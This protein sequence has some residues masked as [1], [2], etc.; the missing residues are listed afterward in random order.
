MWVIGLTGG[1]GS[2]K[3]TVARWLVERGIPVLDADRTVHD[4]LAGDEETIYEIEKEF[5]KEVLVSN[6]GI[7]RKRLGNL[8]FADPLARKRLEGILHPRVAKRM[9]EQQALLA[10]EGQRIC[11]WD[12][13]LLFE[14]GFH[15]WVD[16]IWVVAV[17]KEVQIERI[18]KRDALSKEEVEWRLMAQ[19]PL[20]DKVRQAHVVIDNSG[21]WEATEVQLKRELARIKEEHCL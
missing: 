1:M 13:P 21:S 9:K 5:G 17:P 19:L 4:L 15:Y 10:A 20:E 14:A 12:V 2:G 8:V 6:G 18:M 16:E 11:V 7:H 3:S